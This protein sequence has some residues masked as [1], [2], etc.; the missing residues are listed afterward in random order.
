MDGE[1]L[2]SPSRRAFVRRFTRP[3]EVE[4]PES[5]QPRPSWAFANKLFLAHCD[6]CN[7]CI[8]QCPQGVL[9]SPDEAQPLLQG[10]P[11][12]VL[13][14]GSCDLCIDACQVAAI[15]LDEENRILINSDQCT[16]CGECSLECYNKAIFLVKA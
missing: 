13:D 4:L 7:Q 9:Q 16:G 15:S 5:G 14:Y 11:V 8:K 6:R 2:G 10:L 3:A 1:A 12:L